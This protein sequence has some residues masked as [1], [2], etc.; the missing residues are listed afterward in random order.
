MTSKGNLD[1]WYSAKKYYISL[2]DNNKE[3]YIKYFEDEDAMLKNLYLL[4][5]SQPLHSQ[6]NLSSNGFIDHDSCI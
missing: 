1:Y 6:I 2:Y 5:R 4:R 3:R